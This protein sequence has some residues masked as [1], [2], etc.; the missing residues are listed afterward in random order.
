M[1]KSVMTFLLASVFTSFAFGEAKVG[2]AAPDF[3]VKDATGQTRKLSDYKGKNVVLEW[4]NKDCPYVKKHYGAGNMQK[5]QTELAGKGVAWL[6]VLSSAKGKQGF[7]TPEETIKNGQKE[8]SKAEAF[9][10][11]ADGKIGQMYGA[12][13]TP[14]LFLIDAKGVLRY[15]GAIDSND[16]A[17]PATIAKAENYLLAA[18]TSV[19]K[20]EKIAKETTKPYGCSV[21]Y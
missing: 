12:K 2:Q 14:H 5:L 8:N 19:L 17:D 7:L 16:S 9:L 18:T 6:T 11:D 3:E 13:T 20:G 4:Y 1:K 21:K 10:M 15:N